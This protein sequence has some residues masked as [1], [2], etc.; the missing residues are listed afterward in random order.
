M[1]LPRRTLLV[2]VALMAAM[3]LAQ[4]PASAASAAGSNLVKNGCFGQGSGPTPSSWHEVGAANRF[5]GEGRPP[6]SYAEDLVIVSGQP[7]PAVWQSVPIPAGPATQA[8]LSFWT[9]NWNCARPTTT[10]SAEI[11]EAGHVHV[12]QRLPGS[13][14]NDNWHE[15]SLSI[16]TLRGQAVTVKF[17]VNG[18]QSGDVFYVD[19]VRMVA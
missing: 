10:F 12:L 15:S 14:C 9:R 1:T 3:S 18:T 16:K 11:I 7:S 4:A 17:V 6:C 2:G 8:T 19:N 13:S 5:A